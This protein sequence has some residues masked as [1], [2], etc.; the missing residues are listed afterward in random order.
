MEA[1]GRAELCLC[2]HTAPQHPAELLR[3]LAAAAAV[4]IDGNAGSAVKAADAI[5]FL[6]RSHNSSPTLPISSL[7]TSPKTSTPPSHPINAAVTTG[8]PLL[9]KQQQPPPPSI[10]SQPTDA[11]ATIDA[12][13]SSVA[14]VDDRSPHHPNPLIDLSRPVQ[15][16]EENGEG[17][18]RIV[19]D[20][21]AENE[22]P[23]DKSPG[24]KSCGLKFLPLV[25]TRHTCHGCG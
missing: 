5:M 10:A 11:G 15:G 22:V 9:D 3:Q 14:D 25:R 13:A 8:G 18:D 21:G 7:A 17:E 24:C 4:D 23:S 20:L 1:I 16:G 12:D 19:T 6:Q 2:K